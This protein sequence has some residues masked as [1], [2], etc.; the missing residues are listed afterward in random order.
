MYLEYDP[1]DVTLKKQPADTRVEHKPL[2]IVTHTV[3]IFPPL[4]FKL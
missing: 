4:S 3:F 2:Y 1:N